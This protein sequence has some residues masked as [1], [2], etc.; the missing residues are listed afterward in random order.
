MTARI[1][2]TALVAGLLLAVA[3][4]TFSADAPKTKAD[5]EK[6]KMKWD[7]KANKCTK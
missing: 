7:D 2:G 6:A 4:P 1:L 3:T 5:C